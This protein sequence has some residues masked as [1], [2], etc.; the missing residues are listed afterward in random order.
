MHGRNGYVC[1]IGRGFRGEYAGI[2]N[3]GCEEPNFGRDVEHWEVLDYPHPFQRSA[4]VAC[5][6]FIDDKLRDANLEPV[7][8][9]LPPFLSDLL[10]A[11]NNQIPA[12]P[13]GQIARNGCFQVQ[14][15]LRQDSMPPR[16]I[17]RP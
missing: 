12:G 10:V 16:I 7:L 4:G 3:A 5:T 2:Q 11:S 9:L 15:L 6:G 1:G 14:S 13:R 17:V 8:S